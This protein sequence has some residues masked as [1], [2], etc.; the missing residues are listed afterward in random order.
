MCCG[1]VVKVPRGRGLASEAKKLTGEDRNFSFGDQRLLPRAFHTKARSHFTITASLG[2]LGLLCGIA[3]IRGNG[4]S[5][6]RGLRY[7]FNR[8]KQYKLRAD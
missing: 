3:E 2:L 4:L 1:F 5:W 8:S 6:I 7:F